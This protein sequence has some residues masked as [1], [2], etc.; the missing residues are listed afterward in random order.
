MKYLKNKITG[1]PV[2]GY[3]LHKLLTNLGP[4]AFVAHARHI[5]AI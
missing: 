4:E 5:M 3:E 2:S 1:Q